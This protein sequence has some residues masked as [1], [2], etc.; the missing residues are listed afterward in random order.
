MKKEN[1]LAY[2]VEPLLTWYKKNQKRLPWRTDVTP[3][4]V[5]ISESMLQQTRTAAVIPYYERFLKEL[6]TVSALAAV[7]DDRLLKLWEGLGY[8]S[9]ARNLKRSAEML[10]AFY[11]GVLPDTVEELK[12]L[13]GIGFKSLDGLIRKAK[14][15]Q[16]ITDTTTSPEILAEIFL[17][18]GL[19]EEFIKNY[20]CTS[21]KEIYGWTSSAE[22]LMITSQRKD[23]FD[24]Q[25]LLELNQTLFQNY[26]LTLESL[27]M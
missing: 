8:Y 21:I 17:G 2:I 13:P 4:H 5:W 9:R 19:R 12:K 6:P 1:R 15:N 27:C 24:N 26:P 3:Y 22:R 7:S 20:R 18:E 16:R 11:A 23:R 14:A 25:G 10:M